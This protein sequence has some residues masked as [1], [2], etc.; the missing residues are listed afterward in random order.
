MPILADI[1]EAQVNERRAAMANPA[2][3][4]SYVNP[5]RMANGTLNQE[6]MQR[7]RRIEEANDEIQRGAMMNMG[8]RDTIP[9]PINPMTYNDLMRTAHIDERIHNITA[10]TMLQQMLAK[11]DDILHYVM[12]FI[13]GDLPYEERLADAVMKRL[14]EA[15]T[16][17]ELSGNKMLNNI[18][19]ELSELRDG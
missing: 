4:S 15:M 16:A 17:K 13:D 9:E 12:S 11:D 2:M 3:T 8:V 14:A 5:Y 18:N 7:M 10:T 19:Q 6:V 1:H